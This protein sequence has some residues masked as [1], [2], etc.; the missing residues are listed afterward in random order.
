M[1]LAASPLLRLGWLLILYALRSLPVAPGR[2][3]VR[4]YLKVLELKSG[5]ALPTAAAATSIRHRIQPVN[6]KRDSHFLDNRVAA[7]GTIL[8]GH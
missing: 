3:M 8:W 6:G 7:G 4:G 1:K 2:P 5:L